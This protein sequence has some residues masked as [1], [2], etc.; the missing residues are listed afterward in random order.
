MNLDNKTYDQLRW[1]AQ[2][3]IPAISTFYFTL[4]AI[5]GLPFG[6]QVVGTLAAVDVLLGA[7]LKVSSDNY[8]GDGVL[9]VDSSDPM[10]DK[11]TLAI[12]D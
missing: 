10:V 7:L 11:Y 12:V 1:V 3:G 2:I 8:E 4:C 5:W 6:E 9:Y